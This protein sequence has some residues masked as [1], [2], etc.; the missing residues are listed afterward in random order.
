MPVNEK[1]WASFCDAIG[2]QDLWDL[3]MLGPNGAFGRKDHQLKVKAEIRR[4][5]RTRPRD[6]WVK[7]L[8]A[9]DVPAGPANTYKEV[10]SMPHFRQNGYIQE[11]TIPGYGR[12]AIVGTPTRF[13]ETP[14]EINAT[15]PELGADTEHYLMNVLGYSDAEVSSLAGEKAILP[16]RRPPS[17][18][19]RT[20]SSRDDDQQDEETRPAMM[21][22][23]G[24]IGGAG[25]AGVGRVGRWLRQIGHAVGSAGVTMS[26]VDP[27]CNL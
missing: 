16:L 21:M 4:E 3:T 18:S 22:V 19:A 25:A 9:A 10:A 5:M 7:A 11:A 26:A 15:A 8:L 24:G 27:R 13:S 17:D 23:P 6:D 2:R 1:Q 14:V 12:R 20:T